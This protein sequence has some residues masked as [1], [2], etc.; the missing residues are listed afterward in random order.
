MCIGEVAECD[1]VECT[2]GI[3]KHAFLSLRIFLF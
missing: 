1:Q 3:Y 2:K